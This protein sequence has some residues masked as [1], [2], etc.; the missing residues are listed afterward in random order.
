MN[1]ILAIAIIVLLLVSCKKKES[2]P[3]YTRK[4]QDGTVLYVK[5]D[6]LKVV[7]VYFDT[8]DSTYKVYWRDKGQYHTEWF[9]ETS[10]YGEVTSQ[11]FAALYC[12]Q[13]LKTSTFGFAQKI[14]N[15]GNS[16]KVASSS[17]L[18]LVAGR[19]ISTK[20]N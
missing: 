20:L 14:I 5:P 6:S 16:T 3:E 19:I 8:Y 7:V 4:Y 12:L 1:K 15:N 13:N 2:N 18:L 9:R 11:R 17:R 10:F